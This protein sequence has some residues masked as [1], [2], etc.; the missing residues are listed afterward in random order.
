[1]DSSTSGSAL[2]LAISGEL[3]RRKTMAWQVGGW[4]VLTR[5]ACSVCIYHEQG[6]G[7]NVNVGAA[8]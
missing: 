8:V 3:E 1:M 6:A 5:S 4:V 2:G 7:C